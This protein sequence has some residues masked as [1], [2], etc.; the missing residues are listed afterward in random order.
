MGS[1]AGCTGVC[2]CGMHHSFSAPLTAIEQRKQLLRSWGELSVLC[3][4]C[5]GCCR[6]LLDLLLVA[7]AAVAVAAVAAPQLG[8]QAAKA[9]QALASVIQQAI[10]VDHMASQQ[11]LQ[12]RIPRGGG[13]GQHGRQRRRQ[14]SSSGGDAVADRSI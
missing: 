7:A 11:L 4:R 12:W 10:A 8:A 13:L 2:P 5:C 1:R 9:G 14:S 6:L 3:G